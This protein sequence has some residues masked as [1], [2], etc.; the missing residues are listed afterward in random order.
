MASNSVRKPARQH[1]PPATLRVEHPDVPAARA[2][3]TH[4]LLIELIGYLV[5]HGPEYLCR[6]GMHPSGE[7]RF[8]W[9]ESPQGGRELRC[10]PT[11]R[12]LPVWRERGEQPDQH[13]EERQVA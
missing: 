11:A 3:V 9:S 1:T 10:I 4:P 13:N 8:V 2:L 12:S 6:P 7:L 5:V